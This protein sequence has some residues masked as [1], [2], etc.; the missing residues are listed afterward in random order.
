VRSF[1]QVAAALALLLGAA[2]PAAASTARVDGSTLVFEGGPAEAND[3]AVAYASGT[4]TVTDSGAALIAGSGCSGV[5]T[6]TC[7]GATSADIGGGDGNDRITVGPTTLPVDLHGDAGA[8]QIHS[9]ASNATL[10]YSRASSGVNVI[11]DDQNLDGEEQER[12]ND[13]G[14]F[15]TI[16]GSPYDDQINAATNP[17]TLVGGGGTDILIGNVANDRFVPGP[18]HDSIYGGGGDDTALLEGGNAGGFYSGGPGNDS[19]TVENQQGPFDIFAN[20]RADDGPPGIGH[21]NVQ[22]DWE[23]MTVPSGTVV[24]GSIDEN[25]TVTHGTANGGRGDDRVAGDET[26]I[27]GR[28]R[29]AFTLLNPASN[30]VEAVDGEADR[31]DCSRGVPKSIDIDPIDKA[32]GCG[33]AFK[34]SGKKT[35]RFDSGGF[36]VARLKCASTSSSVPCAAKVAITKGKTVYARGAT[37]SVASGRTARV[38]LKLTSRSRREVGRGRHLTGSLSVTPVKTTHTSTLPAELGR[39]VIR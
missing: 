9:D 3:V 16:V 5:G 32:P 21:V 38:R 33:P 20:G 26:L 28:G 13:T 8:D 1:C 25:I 14:T 27:G 23:T 22:A 7:T 4:W 18:G 37:A 30:V 10:D 11:I 31:I 12:D 24:G 6:V 15:A 34:L 39:V 36:V 17:T 2:A 29:D 35:L 19:L